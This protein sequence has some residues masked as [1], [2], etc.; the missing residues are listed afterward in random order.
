MAAAM[1]APSF[2]S[3]HKDIDGSGNVTGW[4]ITIP[5]V[6]S[7]PPGI[8]T[9]W[10]PSPVGGYVTMHIK[11]FC[12]SGGGG[13]PCSNNSSMNFSS[14][15]EACDSYRTAPTTPGWLGNSSF[16]VVDSI[17]CAAC[18]NPIATGLKPSLVQ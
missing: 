2:D 15:K 16:F 7:C 13:S 17:F 11:L 12:F 9:G 18:D 3:S 4:T 8:T 6:T 5:W 14:P 1:Y 10:T